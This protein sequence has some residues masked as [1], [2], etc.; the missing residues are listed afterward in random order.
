MYHTYVCQEMFGL[1]I[2]YCHSTNCLYYIEFLKHV[3]VCGLKCSKQIDLMNTCI[4]YPVDTV[5]R[6]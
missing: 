4:L 6:L 5:H 3:R 2:G 1:A